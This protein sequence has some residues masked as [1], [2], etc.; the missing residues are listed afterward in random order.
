M[1]IRTVSDP[2]VFCFQTVGFDN[3]PEM[4]A[5]PK[6]GCGV[7]E[8]ATPFLATMFRIVHSLGRCNS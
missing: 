2:S 8:L 6:Y 4:G 5:C 3:V 1:D 7:R